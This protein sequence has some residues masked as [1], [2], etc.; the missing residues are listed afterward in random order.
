MLGKRELDVAQLHSSGHLMLDGG[1]YSGI[2]NT[3]D[4]D[5][6]IKTDDITTG[7]VTLN[8]RI[9]YSG[10]E[11]GIVDE[12]VRLDTNDDQIRSL[13]EHKGMLIDGRFDGKEYTI[14]YSHDNETIQT[15]DNATN[16]FCSLDGT[17]YDGGFYN[18]IYQTFEDKPI[19]K[20]DYPIL[21][22]CA[23]PRQYFVEEGVLP[24]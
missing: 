12:G 5:I 4:D 23:H 20:T 11:K 22:M 19:I 6:H 8:G 13:C 9:I 24:P 18:T 2:F 15:R 3:P 7:I 16:C 10:L 17:L 1:T 21:S 14:C